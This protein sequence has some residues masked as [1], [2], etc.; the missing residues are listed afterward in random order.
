MNVE[1]PVNLGA[2]WKD[3]EPGGEYQILPSLGQRLTRV[4]LIL[5]FTPLALI[6]IILFFVGYTML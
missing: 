3:Q 6:G 5:L 4:L 2:Y 1:A